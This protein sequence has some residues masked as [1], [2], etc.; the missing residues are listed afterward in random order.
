VIWSLT[1][2]DNTG[3]I[4][5]QQDEVFL[6]DFEKKYL[7]LTNLAAGVYYLKYSTDQYPNYSSPAQSVVKPIIIF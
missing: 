5:H 6:G 4:V 7:D 2:Q 1:V 3:R